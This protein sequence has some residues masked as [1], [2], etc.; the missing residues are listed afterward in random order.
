MGIHVVI[1]EKT[2]ETKP[3][4]SRR[5]LVSLVIS[6]TVLGLLF[7]GIPYVREQQRLSFERQNAEWRQNAYQRVKHGDDQVSIMDSKLLPMLASDADCVANLKA[8]YFSMS[9]IADGDA[10]FVSQLSNVQTLSFYD[11]QGADL[12]LKNARELP[13]T[14]MGF[15]MSRLPKDSLR[16]LSEFPELSKV[17]FGHVMF[18][19]EIAILESLPPRIVVDIPYP[20]ENEPWFKERGEPPDAPESR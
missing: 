1:D 3:F 2:S 19:N 12:I 20:A 17:H 7:R 9:E 6:L 14:R 11:C 15:K 4:L 16:T 13:I 8:L 18:P 10:R 5:C